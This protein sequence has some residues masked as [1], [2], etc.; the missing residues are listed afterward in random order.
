MQPQSVVG[1]P[2]IGRPA[3]K[4]PSFNWEADYK[5]S[6]CKNFRLEVNNIFASYSTP[7]TEQLAIV[8]KLVKKERPAIH[9]ILNTG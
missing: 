9:R 5:Y 1:G 2:K 7:H 4:Q 8:K 6:K 3:M